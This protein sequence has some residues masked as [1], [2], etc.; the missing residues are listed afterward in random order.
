MLFSIGTLRPLWDLLYPEV[1]LHEYAVIGGVIV[2]MLS[3]GVVADR[4]GRRVGSLCT[5]LLM[6]VGSSGLL[7][8]SLFLDRVPPILFG[9]ST[10]S[11]IVFGIGVGGEYP[12][13]AASAAEKQNEERGRKLQ[14][15]FSM[16]GVGILLHC[17]LLWILLRILPQGDLVAGVDD[18][19]TSSERQ[20]LLW[21]WR[22][23]YLVGTCLLASVLWSRYLYL[24]ESTAWEETQRTQDQTGRVSPRISPRTSSPKLKQTFSTVS[25][26]SHIS[27]VSSLSAPSVAVPQS[28]SER[29]LPP[30]DEVLP[31]ITLPLFF[32]HYGIRLWG[33]SACWLLWDVAF[34]GNK[35]FQSSFLLALTGNETTLREFAGAATLNAAVALAGYV[36]AAYCIDRVGRKNL[37]LGGFLVTGFLFVGCGL[38][39]SNDKEQ[40]TKAVALY[41]LS[42]FLGQLGPNATTYHIPATVFPTSIRTACHGIAAA[43]GKV[44]ALIAA[45][46]FA[47]NDISIDLF[48]ISGYCSL[49]ACAITAS[50]IPAS[51]GLRED[52]ELR[53]ILWRHK[54]RK[55][56]D[57]WV[58]SGYEFHALGNDI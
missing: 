54:N 55:D 15:V 9:F 27:N 1:Q 43:S 18:A 22:M 56:E 19:L 14:L 58:R 32:R 4:Y 33:T 31:A 13:S 44:G 20:G 36:S 17:I 52:D 25:S 46:C 16:Q 29:T 57:E 42:S 10:V 30:V 24:Q 8:A 3:L 40:S 50:S 12:L 34:Y 2:G 35:L 7:L 38:L 51:D 48:M 26:A 37:Q 53:R 39:M 47:L 49:I 21:V 23:M 11:W 28:P 41:L 5:A 45:V 6:V